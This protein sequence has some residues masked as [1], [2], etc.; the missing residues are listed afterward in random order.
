MAIEQYDS[1]ALEN[2]R[3][4]AAELA[5]LREDVGQK[6]GALEPTK[7]QREFDKLVL[8]TRELDELRARLEPKDLFMITYGV[9]VINVSTVSFVIPKGCSRLEILQEARS[10]DGNDGLISTKELTRWAEDGRFR[11]TERAMSSERI[12]IQGHVAGA[13]SQPRRMQ[14][15]FLSRHGLAIASREDLAVA[16]AVHWVATQSPLGWLLS[17]KTCSYRIRDASGALRYNHGSLAAIVLH[18]EIDDY[19]V[20]VAA[21][22]PL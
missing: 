9:R 16:F 2:Y 21:R 6:I 18:D 8:R 17:E 5:E 10:L 1:K 20:K 22:I 12:C 11:F 3:K 13:W 7:A 14:V 15:D 19:D 4:K